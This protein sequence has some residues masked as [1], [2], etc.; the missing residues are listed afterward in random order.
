MAALMGLDAIKLMHP[1]HNRATIV[2]RAVESALA[3]TRAE[4]EVLVVDEIVGEVPEARIEKSVTVC[5]SSGPRTW[6]PAR[7]TWGSARP[8]CH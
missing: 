8:A 4:D 2:G 6:G 3:A 1:T 5:G 7:A